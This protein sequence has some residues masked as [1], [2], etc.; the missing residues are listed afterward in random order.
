MVRGRLSVGEAPISFR[1]RSRGASKMNWRQQLNFLRHLGRLYRFRFPRT[2]RLLAFG[3][4]GGSGFVVDSAFYF[5]LQWLGASHLLAR[6]L[7][8][9]PAVSWNWWLNRVVTFRDRPAMPRTGQW[10]RFAATS[11]TGL[12]VN[13]GSYWALTSWVPLFARE[14]FLA[15]ALGVAIGSLVNFAAANRFVYRPAPPGGTG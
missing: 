5:G 6:F 1:D 15:L 13:F 3:L 7:S 4:V 11:L 12:A 14:R 2:S 10:G 8:F 9:W